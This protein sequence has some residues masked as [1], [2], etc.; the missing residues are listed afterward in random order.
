MDRN[1]FDR[2]LESLAKHPEELEDS[3]ARFDRSPPHYPIDYPSGTTTQ[4]S[5]PTSLAEQ[6]SREECYRKILQERNASLPKKQ[7]AH[8]VKEERDVVFKAIVNRTFKLPPGTSIDSVARDNVVARWVEQGI[9]NDKWNDTADG[10]WKHEE[11]PDISSE[12]GVQAGSSTTSLKK[13]PWRNRRKVLGQ[14]PPTREECER[15]ASRPFYQFMYQVSRAKEQ[16]LYDL[17]VEEDSMYVPEDINTRAYEAVKDT[18][19]KRGIWDTKWLILPGTSWK[20]EFPLDNDLIAYEKTM[21][22]K[23]QDLNPAPPRT[24]KQVRFELPDEPEQDKRS[25]A[26]SETPSPSLADDSPRSKYSTGVRENNKRKRSPPPEEFRSCDEYDST[27][28]SSPDENELSE[29]DSEAAQDERCNSSDSPVEDEI[30]SD[31]EPLED[32]KPGA[33][34]IKRSSKPKGIRK[35]ERRNKGKEKE[36]KKKVEEYYDSILDEATQEPKSPT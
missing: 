22:L 5:T 32:K 12:P 18:W 4:C 8:Q 2:Y 27:D 16:I 23:I 7:L 30:M 20:H 28:P 31:L 19:T 13:R 25:M 35:K 3:R 34:G 1:A 15:R 33:G 6:I 21:N 17:C 10:V 11:L 14:K 24:V 29:P 9:W 36:L 26:S